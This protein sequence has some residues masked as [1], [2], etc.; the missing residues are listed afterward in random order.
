MWVACVWTVYFTVTIKTNKNTTEALVQA[1]KINERR[2]PGFQRVVFVLLSFLEQKCYRQSTWISEIERKAF[3]CQ[4]LGV[5]LRHSSRDNRHQ[6]SKS[7]KIAT[8]D[9]TH[10]RD[11]RQSNVNHCD[12][13]LQFVSTRWLQL[14]PPDTTIQIWISLSSQLWMRNAKRARNKWQNDKSQMAATMEQRHRGEF[15]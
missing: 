1:Y 6:T 2:T 5:W 9:K 12:L 15:Y 10:E 14:S 11:R 3:H 8:W 4:F 7:R 13:R